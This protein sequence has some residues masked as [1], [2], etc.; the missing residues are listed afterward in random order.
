MQKTND[1]SH[2]DHQTQHRHDHRLQNNIKRAH[3]GATLAVVTY[4]Q[5][6]ACLHVYLYFCLCLFSAYLAANLLSFHQP[7]WLVNIC[8][9]HVQKPF[10]LKPATCCRASH[11]LRYI[12]AHLVYMRRARLCHKDKLSCTVVVPRLIP[13]ARSFAFPFSII[14]VWGSWGTNSYSAALIGSSGVVQVPCKASPSKCDKM[15]GIFIRNRGLVWEK[16]IK[17]SCRNFW[18]LC[19]HPPLS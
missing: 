15:F 2:Q 6:S 17:K 4:R 19:T 18:R 3:T 1:E 11:A 13:S 16:P 5:D 14:P 7:F 8:L 9:V 10:L 12:W